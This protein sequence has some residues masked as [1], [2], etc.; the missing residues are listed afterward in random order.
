MAINWSLVLD[1]VMICLL[2]GTLVYSFVLNRNL[3]R[4]REAKAEFE[5][6]V[7]KLIIS[8]NKAET[9]LRD[10]KLSAQEVGG[11]LEENVAN[12]RGLSQELQFM[13]ESGDSLANRLMRASE[14][15]APEASR[16]QPTLMMN[17]KP[18]EVAPKS[19]A[20]AQLMEDLTRVAEARAAA[21]KEAS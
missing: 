5:T 21:A 4:L 18:A 15:N 11:Q 13:I 9:G 14:S 2:A 12:A 1:I 7:Q 19:R 6:V 20:E 10:M 17:K 16:P 8:I 3:S